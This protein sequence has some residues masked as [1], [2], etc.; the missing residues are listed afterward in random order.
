[1]TSVKSIGFLQNYEVHIIR[2]FTND[3]DELVV[4]CESGDDDLGEHYLVTG[5]DFHWRFRVNFFK[6]TLFFCHVKWGELEQRFNAFD[7]DYIS[8]LCEETSKCFWSLSEDGIYFSCDD[9]NYVK[10]FEWS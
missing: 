7:T 5:D 8:Y 1:M 10:Q 2:R 3:S 9:K 4:R 6:S